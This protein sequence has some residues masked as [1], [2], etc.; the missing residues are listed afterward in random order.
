FLAAEPDGTMTGLFAVQVDTR[1]NE[2]V[3]LFSKMRGRIQP[4]MLGAIERTGP[5]NIVK[6]ITEQ[7]MLESVVQRAQ[8]TADLSISVLGALATNANTVPSYLLAKE[9]ESA[10][11][12]LEQCKKRAHIEGFESKELPLFD[13]MAIFHQEGGQLTPSQLKHAADFKR[14]FQ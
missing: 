12:L 10:K 3:E 14:A 1:P 6:E 9:Q 4:I 8:V 13:H 7:A 11:M 2:A 5:V